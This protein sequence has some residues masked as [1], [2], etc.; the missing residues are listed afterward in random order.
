[1]LLT[2]LAGKTC[3]QGDKR[4]TV[5]SRFGRASVSLWSGP[6]QPVLPSTGLG[7]L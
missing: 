3:W 4:L 2:D 5:T 7:T 6:C 1:M